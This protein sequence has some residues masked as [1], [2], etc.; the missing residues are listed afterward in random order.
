MALVQE[1]LETDIG[2][3]NTDLF[4]GCGTFKQH[5]TNSW[6]K[7]EAIVRGQGIIFRKIVNSC[8]LAVALFQ[9]PAPLQRSVVKGY[10]SSVARRK[11]VGLL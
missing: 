3:R 11:N 9:N 6:P 2:K 4:Q 10:N 1:L 5:Q 8:H 7:A